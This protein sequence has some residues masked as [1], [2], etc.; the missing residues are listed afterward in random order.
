[1]V[2]QY[3][4]FA[5]FAFAAILGALGVITVKNP[6][7]SI[8]LMVWTFFSVAGLFILQGAEFL[9][10]LLMIVYVGAIA[11]LF[12]FIVMMMN[13][14]YVQMRQGF[15]KNL[16]LGIGVGVVLVL[17]L[18]MAIFAHKDKLSKIGKPFEENN[19]EVLG[20]LLYTEYVVMFLI[21]SV[22]LLVAL[23]GAIT[24]THR[25]RMDVKRQDPLKQAM[26]QPSDRV[27]IV[28]VKSGEGL[29]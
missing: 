10:F 14:D 21:A 8:L 3:M 6:V 25:R 18:F 28:K 7:Y 26:T 15:V 19:L 27:S 23:I 9:A 13:I 4:A 11:V 2:V 29:K 16:P 17:E 12:L 5:L 1:M 20:G 24:L 22:I